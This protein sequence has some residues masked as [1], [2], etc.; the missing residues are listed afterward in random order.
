[1]CYCCIILISIILWLFMLKA[2]L[3]LPSILEF[4]HKLLFLQKGQ[5]FG[6]EVI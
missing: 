3:L 6:W 2:E 5:L 4:D 1:M